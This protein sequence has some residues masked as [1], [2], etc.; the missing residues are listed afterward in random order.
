MLAAMQDLLTRADNGVTKLSDEEL[1][2]LYER[3]RPA[4]DASVVE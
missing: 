4:T 3:N 1:L 2:E